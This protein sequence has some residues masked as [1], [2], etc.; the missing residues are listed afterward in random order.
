MRQ[1]RVVS[2]KYDGRLRGEY[3]A[4]LYRATPECL[5]VF[6]PPGTREYD[7]RKQAWVEG[8]DGLLELYFPARWYSVWHICEQNSRRNLI[9]AHISM[10]A[11][12]AGDLLE[13]VDLELDYRVHLD[14]SI[15]RL[16]EEEFERASHA[17][18]YPPHVIHSA[19]AAC[20]EIEDLYR[21]R[22]YPF[23][24]RDQVALYQ[25]IGQGPK[26]S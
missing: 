21:Q 9:Y 18:G 2:R 16:D 4:F 10:P 14:E 15:E 13:W 11:V 23:N 19:R 7:A 24:H 22:A 25:R 17:L 26:G 8:P 12:L 1:I 5:V 6:T 20:V 3:T